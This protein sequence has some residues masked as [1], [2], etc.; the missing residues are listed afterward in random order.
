MCGRV[1]ARVLVL[2]FKIKRISFL[3]E[4]LQAPKNPA[5]KSAP[6]YG[7]MPHGAGACG[8]LAKRPQAPAPIQT[9]SPLRDAPWSG[10]RAAG[11]RLVGRNARACV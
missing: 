9:G 4:N 5:L 6:L 3:L 1:L 11:A 8:V 2:S 7:G 10:G